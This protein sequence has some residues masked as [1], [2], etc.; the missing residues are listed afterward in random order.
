MVLQL[1]RTERISVAFPIITVGAVL[2]IFMSGCASDSEQ[3][4][5][6]SMASRDVGSRPERPAQ[7]VVYDFAVTPEELPSDAPLGARLS[8]GISLTPEQMAVGRQL[9]SN[10]AAQLVAAIQE[11]GF[12][13]ERTLTASPLRADIV[14]VRGCF[15]SSRRDDTSKHLMVGFDLQSGEMRTAVECFQVT[16]QGAGRPLNFG[17]P[18]APESGSPITVGTANLQV[19]TNA[20][21]VIFTHSIS[22][23]DESGFRSNMD[24]WGS[25]TA[26]EIA[27]ELRI[28]FR[29]EGW[30]D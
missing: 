5:A 19:G 1:D 29:S 2:L 9:G 10:I 8:S 16:P 15:I 12:P 13:A 20:P 25:Q 11:M 14:V 4:A 30:V 18:R 21:G 22:F 7:V 3:G 28:L 23:Q 24:S 6:P 27:D 17:S 26:R